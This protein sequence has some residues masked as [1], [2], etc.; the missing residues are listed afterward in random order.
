MSC[1]K[2]LNFIASLI[3][4]LES[5]Q[6]LYSCLCCTHHQHNH[7]NYNNT[8][9]LVDDDG[10]GGGYHPFIE[11]LLKTLPAPDTVWAIEGRAAW[12]EA[13]ASV[14]KLLYRGDGRISITAQTEPDKPN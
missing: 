3:G 11:G 9:V 2:G 8:Y 6:I 12:L 13:A 4:L 14:F 10:D 5:P 7:Q 1:I